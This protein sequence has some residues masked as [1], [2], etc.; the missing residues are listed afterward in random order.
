VTFAQSLRTAFF[1]PIMQADDMTAAKAC[2]GGNTGRTSDMAAL[3][4]FH[5][6]E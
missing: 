6:Y 2:D 3:A 5:V 1:V 4:V